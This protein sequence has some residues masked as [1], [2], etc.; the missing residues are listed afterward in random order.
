MLAKKL[1]VHFLEQ[2]LSKARL[3]S[4]PL[5]ENVFGQGAG[6]IAVRWLHLTDSPIEF[7]CSDTRLL[8]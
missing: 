4:I 5:E 3:G 6:T 7:Q 8:T 2:G 1:I